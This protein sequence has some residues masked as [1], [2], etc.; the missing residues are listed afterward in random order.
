MIESLDLAG[1]GTWDRSVRPFIK[2]TTK[3]RP[4]REDRASRSRTS[5]QMRIGPAALC[6]EDP[7]QPPRLQ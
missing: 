1:Q 5:E 7:D 4:S 3:E 6:D 2:R